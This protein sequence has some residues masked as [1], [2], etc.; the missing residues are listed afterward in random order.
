MCGKDILQM[1]DPF[2]WRAI[3]FTWH[4]RIRWL[5]SLLEY[6]KLNCKLFLNH[7]INWVL[8]I[9]SL[10]SNKKLFNCKHIYLNQ[11]W[12]R[13]FDSFILTLD[14]IWKIF[15]KFWNVDIF[16]IFNWKNKIHTLFL[17]QNW[18]M[19]GFQTLS[20]YQSYFWYLD[21]ELMKTLN[22]NISLYDK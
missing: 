2:L 1:E 18:Y 20:F 16:F 5:K 6:P 3:S 13:H 4:N 15:S 17:P 22:I 11:W 9:K 12:I 10:S 19:I 14:L 8:I 7:I 21:L